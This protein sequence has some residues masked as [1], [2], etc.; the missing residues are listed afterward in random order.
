MKTIPDGLL[1]KLQNLEA[2][3]TKTFNNNNIFIDYDMYEELE[4]VPVLTDE[5]IAAANYN[6]KHLTFY[7]YNPNIYKYAKDEGFKEKEIFEKFEEKL[8][9]ELTENDFYNYLRKIDS[10]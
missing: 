10:K 7:V 1:K 3:V 2:Y 6:N 9:F 5:V 8:F 4:T